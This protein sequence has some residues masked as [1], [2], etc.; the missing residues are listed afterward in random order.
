MNTYI[1]ISN[2]GVIDF[3]A[4]TLLGASTKRNDATK[5]GEYGSGLN[6]AIAWLMRNNVTFRVFAG[7]QEVK[8]AKHPTD[9]RGQQ[10]DIICVNGQPTSFTTEMGHDWKP[11]FVLR[12]LW[13]NALDEGGEDLDGCYAGEIIPAGDDKTVFYI[14]TT[15]ELMEVIDRWDEYFCNKREIIAEA[16][17]VKL[18]AGKGDMVVYRK[19]VR[20]H[21]EKGVPSAFHYDFADIAINEARV[22]NN[23][24]ELRWKLAEWFAKHAPA[25]ALRILMSKMREGDL[26]E[27]GLRFEYQHTYSHAWAEALGGRPVVE[28]E[29]AGHYSD[30]PQFHR[31]VQLPK[32]IIDKLLKT[33]QNITHVAGIYSKAGA[34][35]RAATEKEAYTLKQALYYLKEMQYEI[36]FDVHVCDFADSLQ[37][38][39]YCDNAIYIGGQAFNTVATLCMTLMEENEHGITGFEDNTRDFQNHLLQ[40]WFQQM[41]ITYAVT[42]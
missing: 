15:P 23:H 22:L 30:L 27:H 31:A 16:A 17:G 29:I 28:R 13:C 24:W 41:K 14:A 3:G 18:Y 33:E 32:A 6:Y 8:F 26:F 35:V 9:M 1:K 34:K 25:K 7:M 36:R 37:S 19:G 20:I 2:N 40:R 11:W 5:I 12:E 42:I 38:G 4:F 10:F 21:T 39:L